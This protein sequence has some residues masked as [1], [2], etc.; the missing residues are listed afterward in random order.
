MALILVVDDDR[1]FSK[2]LRK[3]LTKE[4]YAVVGV[5]T[6][7]QMRASLLED[8]PDLIFLDVNLPDGNG[9]AL[10]PELLLNE[11]GPEVLVITGV[12][13]DRSAKMAVEHGAWDYI[14]KS[15]PLDRVQIAAARA[16]RFREEKKAALSQS[17]IRNAGVIG[18]SPPMRKTLHQASRAAISDAPVL[19]TGETG[20]G[21]EMM[22]RA[23]HD[24]GG[25][26]KGEF[27]IVDCASLPHQLAESILFGHKKGA[28]TGADTD[29]HG[30]I[31]MADG[32]TLFLD[33]VGELPAETQK[34]FLRVLQEK[35]YRPVGAEK[36]RKS[37]FRVLAAT[38]RD[39]TKIIEA[40][41]FRSDL[42]HRL[43][44]ILIHLPPLRER[45]DDIANLAKYR[46][47]KKTDNS[48]SV[49]GFHP[50]IFEV[51][52][53]Y[54]W[55]GNIREL[56]QVI[57][58]TY[59]NAVGFTMIHS[60][61]IP[62]NI[63]ARRGLG[64]RRAPPEARQAPDPLTQ[65]LEETRLAAILPAE[66]NYLESLCRACGGDYKRACEISGL[67]KSRLYGLLD[68][69]GLSMGRR[70]AQG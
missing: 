63:R 49:K 15:D 56:F 23:I 3:A 54:E 16:L 70:R 51:L 50:E 55:P 21:K 11:D 62:P 8:P 7:A 5:E 43:S 34:R 52:E 13:D 38:N 32:G 46:L 44:S 24:N 64:E 26:R 57:D 45:K 67:S 42:F 35:T 10:L 66:K 19:I 22:A 12:P 47:A 60:I 27:V 40:G 65:T 33:E 25:R 9:L 18:T 2:F 30:L 48:G 36:E 58:A 41:Q 39:L 37:D 1:T 29:H 28:F 59:A 31:E 17:D 20:T 6:I 61:H 69:H 14:C 68:K 4:G 53:S